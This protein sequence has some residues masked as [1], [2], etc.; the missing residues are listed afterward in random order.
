MNIYDRNKVV[1][2]VS[3]HLWGKR[4]VVLN[5][6]TGL[7]YPYKAKSTGQKVKSERSFQVERPEKHQMIIKITIFLAVK[8]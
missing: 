8:Y 6:A 5:S 1:K 2:V 3:K 4:V 7:T